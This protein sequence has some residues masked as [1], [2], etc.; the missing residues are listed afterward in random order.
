MVQYW[1]MHQFEK[2][3]G[4]RMEAKALLKLINVTKIYGQGERR[5]TALKDINLEI[6]EGE[7]VAL[8]GP[9]GCG[10]S[11]L[12][13]MITGLTMPSEGRILYR[14]KQVD[15]VNPNATIVFQTFALY[16]WLSVLDNVALALRARGVEAAE[17]HTE[18]VGLIDVV[19]LDGFEGAYPR[20]LSGGMRQ[21]V[22]FARALAV[23]PELLCLDE[24]FSALDV[25]SAE[26][27]RGELMELWTGGKLPIK[28]ILM[29]S[30]N[31]EEALAMADRIVVMGKEPGHIAIEFA[32][33][34]PQPRD[35]KD[36]RLE[37]YM[38]RIYAAIA[39][40]TLPEATEVGALPGAPGP[41]RQLPNASASELAGLLEQL[42]E[43]ML[44]MDIYK[45]EDDLGLSMT[46][47]IPIIEMAEMLGFAIVH[48]GDIEL[49]PLGQAF[50]EASILTRKE[51]FAQRAR[52]LPMIQW[53]MQMLNATPAQKLPRQVFYA[54][55]QPEFPDDV[56]E[57]QLDISIQWGRYAELI[58]YDD[59]DETV[60][61]DVSNVKVF[62]PGTPQPA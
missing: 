52:R 50:A 6:V 36:P 15:G 59:R 12:L 8:L 39:G 47:L 1:D 42:D 4:V 24:P 9:S 28:A 57:R 26:S 13:R 40:Q 43:D 55:L 54:A 33:G 45:L 34:L 53:M 56:A 51:L 25:L 48:E 44:R 35:R 3:E 7:F 31:I 61:L 46:D 10:K 17:A 29:V 19:G 32:V 22:G 60:S 21:K 2:K 16:P 5:F 18:A 49:T 58:A 27:L 20:E 11:T 62:T 30:H 37:I 14:G 23:K 41:T 38:D